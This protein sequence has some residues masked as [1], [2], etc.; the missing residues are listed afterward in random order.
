MYLFFIRCEKT[1]DLPVTREKTVAETSFLCG[2]RG[3]GESSNPLTHVIKK[4]GQDIKSC[5]IF[6]SNPIGLE[7]VRSTFHFGRC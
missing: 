2:F 5:P 7:R 3:K 4:M 6:C 1:C